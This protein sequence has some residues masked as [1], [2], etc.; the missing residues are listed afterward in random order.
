M[1]WI[2]KTIFEIACENEATVVAE[3]FDETA[4]SGL[5]GLGI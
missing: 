4:K 1:Q 2:D 5:S 3:F